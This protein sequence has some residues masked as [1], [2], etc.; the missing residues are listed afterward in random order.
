M[1][2]PARNFLTFGSVVVAVI[3]AVRPIDPAVAQDTPALHSDDV[4]DTGISGYG[5]SPAAGR[6]DGAVNGG[7]DHG[8]GPVQALQAM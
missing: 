1:A 5:Y 3:A 4:T 2:S 6:C 7:S 8:G